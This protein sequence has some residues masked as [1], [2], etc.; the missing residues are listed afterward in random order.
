MVRD[1]ST[2]T[3]RYPNTDGT[4]LGETPVG[5]EIDR[6]RGA[7]RIESLAAY[8][9]QYHPEAAE[10]R[11]Q[12]MACGRKFASL[13]GIHHQQYEGKAFYMDDEGDIVRRHVKGRVMVDAIGF[14]E[15]KT[16]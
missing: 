12:L 5:I 9:L 4:V 3:A 7:K 11:G 10:M 1:A 13:M 2:S 14:Q 16:N 8:P 6:F 15:N